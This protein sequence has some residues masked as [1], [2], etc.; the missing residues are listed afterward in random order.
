MSEERTVSDLKIS[1]LDSIIKNHTE[2]ITVSKIEAVVRSTMSDVLINFGIDAEKPLDVQK[3]MIFLD[4]QRRG[5]DKVVDWG[6]KSILLAAISGGIALFVYGFK[7]WM[8]K[9]F[10]EK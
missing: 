10:L 9:V 2:N 6:K 3:N 5:T 8:L 4:K 1:E 7:G